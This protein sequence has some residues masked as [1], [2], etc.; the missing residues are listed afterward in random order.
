MPETPVKV[1]EIAKSLAVDP[2]TIRNYCRRYPQYLSP[3]ANPANGG[4][5]LFTSRDVALLSFIHSALHSGMNHAEISMKLHEKSFNVDGQDIVVGMVDVVPAQAAQT[6]LAP[7]A[8]P[9]EIS[10]MRHEIDEIRATQRLLLRA[11]VLWGALL[12]AIA[13]LVAGGFM[14]WVLWLLAH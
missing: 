2:N 4:T 9:A 7:L 8:L 13:A 14:L 3:S 6:A 5:R 11:A 12:G 1:G 10:I